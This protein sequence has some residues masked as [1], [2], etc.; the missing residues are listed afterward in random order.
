MKTRIITALCLSLMLIVASTANAQLKAGSD[1]DKAFTKIGKEKNVD[2][3]VQLL[4]DFEKTFPQSK[5]LPQVYMMLVDIYNDK[6]DH[7]KVAE[8]GEKALKVDPTSVTAYVQ[9]SRVYAMDRKNLDVAVSYAQKA[10][11]N[12]EKMKAQPAPSNYTD[13]EWKELIKSNEE[14]AKSQLTYAKAV[15]Q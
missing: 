2:A 15:K 12:V 7:A 6:N 5:A 1:E 4:I 8:Y 11:D 10:V 14:A 9:V 3:Q 13:A